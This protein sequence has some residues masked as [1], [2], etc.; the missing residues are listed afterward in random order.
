MES[1]QPD[2]LESEELDYE[3]PTWIKRFS[4]L[5]F[6]D[7]FTDTNHAFDFSGS[8]AGHIHDR[9]QTLALIYAVLGLL[10]IGIDYLTVPGDKLIHLLLI[11]VVVSMA[12]F[13]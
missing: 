6:S 1:N 7:L 13:A 5:N 2:N 12:F 3:R 11:R 8:R 10:W 4:F 9:I